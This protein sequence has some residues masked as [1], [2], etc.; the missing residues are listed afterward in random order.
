MGISSDKPFSILGTNHFTDLNFLS[1]AANGC[2]ILPLYR[3]D[4]NGNRIEN[5]TDWGLEQFKNKYL[6]LSDNQLL[7]PPSKF[8]ILPKKQY[9]TT[10]TQYCTTPF[11]AK[12]TSRI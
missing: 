3:Y 11:T 4:E 7:T 6:Q 5:I 2:R 10:F 8:Q 9:F 1:P 12:N